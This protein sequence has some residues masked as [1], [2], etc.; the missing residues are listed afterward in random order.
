MH[1]TI[2]DSPVGA[3]LLARDEAVRVISIQSGKKTTK[4]PRVALPGWI[5]DAN[6]L[7]SEVEQMRAYFAGELHDFDMVLEPEGTPFQRRV[8]E[9]L[10]KVPYGT[11][12][13]YGAL[14]KSLDIP[15]AARAVGA[16]NGANPIGIVVPCHRV[17]G[18]S[19]ALTGYGGGLENKEFLLAHERRYGARDD[20]ATPTQASL[21]L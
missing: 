18:S 1:Y 17:V 11:T 10:V 5:R 16:A 19:G 7:R 3:I 12:T 4:K 13:T 14:A 21:A 2:M 20:D 6:A 8:W 15:K 9:A